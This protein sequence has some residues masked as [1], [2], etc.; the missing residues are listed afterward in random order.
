MP[1]PISS[2]RLPCTGGLWEPQATMV[3][4]PPWTTLRV[5]YVDINRFSGVDSTT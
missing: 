4:P 3:R 2:K 5:D 1:L